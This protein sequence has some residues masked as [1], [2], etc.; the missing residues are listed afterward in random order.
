MQP[1]PRAQ[2]LRILEVLHQD[3]LRCIRER[4]S[5]AEELREKER[6]IRALRRRIWRLSQHKGGKG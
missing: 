4:E 3:H 6:R 1:E 5:Q 2:S